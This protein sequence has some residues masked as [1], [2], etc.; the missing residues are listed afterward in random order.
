MGTDATKDREP[1][2]AAWLGMLY[3]L[4]VAALMVST[5]ALWWP[6]EART[7]PLVPLLSQF[8]DWP[9]WADRIST[10]GIGAGLLF[11]AASGMSE[12]RS[13]TT[14]EKTKNLVS[15]GWR[16][17]W[18]LTSI[19]ALLLIVLDQQRLQPWFYQ[20][21]LTSVVFATCDRASSLK[22]IRVLV[23]SVYFFS[24]L[25]KF[26]YQFIHS[27][28]PDF[29]Q[30]LLSWMGVDFSLLTGNQRFWFAVSLPMF[31]L[32]LAIALCISWTMY[33]PL[34]RVACLAAILFHISL[35]ILFSNLGLGH[36]LGVVLWNVQF[37]VQA[38]LLFGVS[39]CQGDDSRL[40]DP[41]NWLAIGSILVVA[42]M[43]LGERFGRWDHWPSWALYAPH[44]SRAEVYVATAA[45]Q[46]LPEPLREQLASELTEDE[47]AVTLWY[48]VPI[49]EWC[50]KETGT[51]IY[52]QDRLGVA[53][54]NYLRGV[55]GG[56]GSYNV[57]IDLL[58]IAGRF[59]GRRPELKRILRPDDF[60]ALNK[61]FFLNTQPRRTQEGSDAS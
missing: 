20:A 28:A 27:V 1:P 30:T 10:V 35:A 33:A 47:D 44:S 52:P 26:D 38:W 60:T 51:P 16:G 6:T 45:V 53:V 14:R 7:F 31:E 29:L 49:K 24:A 4:S 48:R 9:L 42:L 22:L 61:R 15:T 12:F 54:G 41:R 5:S 37:A 36:S 17:G 59:D 19:F 34:R 57:R 21:F 11:V 23:I 43:P 25:G 39:P 46:R 32:I 2:I 56:A 8:C 40:T 55:L 58:G 50:L 18:L 13:A 3:A